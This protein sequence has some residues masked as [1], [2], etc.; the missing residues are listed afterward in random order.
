MTYVL[1]EPTILLW[2]IATGAPSIYATTPQ[3]YLG[4]LY[5]VTWSGNSLGPE[6]MVGWLVGNKV[7]NLFE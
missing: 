3:P 1:I 6:I 2:A 5:I 4:V 7:D